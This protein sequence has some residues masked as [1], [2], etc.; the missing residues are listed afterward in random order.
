MLIHNHYLL[1]DSST[2][3]SI[4]LSPLPHYLA[5][6][7]VYRGHRWLHGMGRDGLQT[8]RL[9]PG[10]LREGEKACSRGQGLPGLKTDSTAVLKHHQII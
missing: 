8:V 2:F 6:L 10:Q 9:H 4:N 7:A 3:D 5:L 1:N